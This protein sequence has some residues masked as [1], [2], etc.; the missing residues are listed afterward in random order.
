MIAALT[1]MGGLAVLVYTVFAASF[2]SG[3]DS[4]ELAGGAFVV[5]NA[6]LFASVVAS[7]R[8]GAV[9]LMVSFFFLFFVALPAYVQ[10]DAGVFP[11]ASTYGERQIL[12]GIVAVSMFQIIYELSTFVRSPPITRRKRQFPGIGPNVVRWVWG[13]NAALLAGALY[14]GPSRLFETRFGNDDSLG[15]EVADTL[16]TQL[17][18]VGRSTS[19]LLL[20]VSLLIMR[21][22]REV[23]VH[24]NQMKLAVFSAAVFLIYNFPPALP[25]FQLLGA[26]LAVSLIFL[27]LFKP[28]LKTLFSLSALIFLFAVFPNLKSLAGDQ[29]ALTQ[30]L[31]ASEYLLRAD[32]DAFKQV[33]DTITYLGAGGSLRGIDSATGL[34]FFW[35]PRSVW[36]S[37]P[38]SAGEL[39]ASS[40]GHPYTNVSSPIPAEALLAGGAF[41]LALVAFLMGIVIVKLENST[42]TSL[43]EAN[44]GVCVALYAIAAGYT[45]IIMRGALNAVGPMVMPGFLLCAVFAVVGLRDNRLGNE[46][47]SDGRANTLNVRSNRAR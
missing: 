45:T 33:V 4:L 12:S 27:D 15:G 22:R 35:I 16:A 1:K 25:R 40:L 6:L 31:S 11:F 7:P 21:G 28:W 29:N 19:I 37:K 32:F 9:S 34:L 18:L 13:L 43:R 24:R 46:R 8:R 26:M 38:I 41:G 17:L 47:H 14:L 5:G 3:H 39:V 42:L 23:G 2:G 44:F 20:V 36:E 10:T 30:Q